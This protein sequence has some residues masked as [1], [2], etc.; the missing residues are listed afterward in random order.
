MD[1]LSR[2]WRVFCR[3]GRAASGAGQVWPAPFG[4]P[5]GLEPAP[6][7]THPLSAR[8]NGC[9]RTRIPNEEEKKG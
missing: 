6:T 9:M 5:A 8:A 1:R 3:T 2:A 7:H 4:T